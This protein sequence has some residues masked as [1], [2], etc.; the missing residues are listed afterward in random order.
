MDYT[1]EENEED[2]TE[3][4][5]REEKSEY[6]EKNGGVE[7]EEGDSSEGTIMEMSSDDE[8][9]E[10]H[11]NKER[12]VK[13]RGQVRRSEREKKAPK[14][15]GDYVMLLTY[16]QAITGPD[17]IKWKEAIKEEKDSLKKNNTR[18]VVD[19]EKA[20]NKKILSSKWIFKE[21]D[22]GQSKARLV[23]RG[24]EQRHG[25]D[26]KDVFSSVVNNCSLR[27]LFATAVKKN[28]QI[29]TFAIKTAFLYGKLDEEVYMQPPQGNDYG[30]KICKLK[31]ALY[32]LKQAPTKWNQTFTAALKMK[33]LKPLKNEQC[34]F[35]N[36]NETLI[37]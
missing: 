16:Q 28:Y 26:F 5:V 18:K 32:G 27:I 21:K 17:R 33:G 8:D 2:H 14:R 1:K 11:S 22:N 13:D 20:G 23:I 29:V 3:Q 31:K 34:I 12:N 15:Y 30:G 7:M 19:K 9:A 35:K 10:E 25:I 24:C 36:K 4:E 37:L 6:E